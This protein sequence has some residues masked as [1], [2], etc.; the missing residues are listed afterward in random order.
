[1]TQCFPDEIQLVAGHAFSV[2]LAE[3]VLA[4]AGAVKIAGGGE[5]VRFAASELGIEPG[6][7]RRGS[8][9]AFRAALPKA[10]KTPHFALF[11]TNQDLE[12]A[13]Y[14]GDEMY[15]VSLCYPPETEPRATWVHTMVKVARR[16]LELPAFAHAAV[17][18]IARGFTNFVPL[19]PIAQANH[20]VIT[21]EAE[22]ADAYDDPEAFWCAWQ[23]IDM[24]GERRLCTRGLADLDEHSW[25]ARTFESTMDMAR[26]AK[27]DLTTYYA[28][29]YWS[30]EF[31]PWWEFGDYQAEKAGYPALAPLGYD[32]DTRAFEL[33]GFITKT[34]LSAG[35]FEP[36]HVLIREIYEL[37][38]LARR[39]Q[40]REGQPLDAVNVIW[41]E[42]WMAQSE[43]RPLLDVGA[44]VFY[45]DDNKQRVPV[46]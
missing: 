13:I 11:V 1:M 35:G 38:K 30:E 41:P 6:E 37:R 27:A 42:R 29:P 19:P 40:V 46:T 8:L 25:L 5:V 7:T 34:P 21:T 16:A 12:L 33:M 10:G 43:R 44:H 15:E 3:L 31:A 24:I 4:Y 17:K 23:T 28:K 2:P 32:P 14:R 22:V 45:L 39:K 9:A 20:F 36:R 26:S 18:R